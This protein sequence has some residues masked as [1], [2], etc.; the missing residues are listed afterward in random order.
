MRARSLE[1]RPPAADLWAGVAARIGA[2]VRTVVLPV[3]R[4]L[5]LLAAPA[6]AAGIALTVLSGGGAW[7]LH[8]VV[9][10]VTLVQPAP[11]RPGR[12]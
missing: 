8:P 1:D 6:P 9:P 5:D 3:R 4:R 10:T 11:R 12:R 7:L 2:P